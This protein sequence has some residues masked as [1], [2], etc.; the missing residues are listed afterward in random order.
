MSK[1]FEQVINI[2]YYNNRTVIFIYLRICDDNGMIRISEMKS[3]G[4]TKKQR[5]EIFRKLDV[6]KEWIMDEWINILLY[7]LITISFSKI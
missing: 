2:Q 5:K 6:D 4:K 7:L 1:V 3:S